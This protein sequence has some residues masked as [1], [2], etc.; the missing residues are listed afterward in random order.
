MD[1]RAEIHERP[2]QKK[3]CVCV[4]VCV[5]CCVCVCVVCVC[6]VCVCVPAALVM[7]RNILTPARWKSG[8]RSLC[9]CCFFL[10]HITQRVRTNC[11]KL[12]SMSDKLYANTVIIPFSNAHFSKVLI[13]LIPTSSEIL[14]N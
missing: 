6:C 7:G 4:C 9:L 2:R 14:P 13:N 10:P 12:K 5:V 8:P 1:V 3:V 11:C